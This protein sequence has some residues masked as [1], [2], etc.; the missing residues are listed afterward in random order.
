MRPHTHVLV[1]IPRQLHVLGA[2]PSHLHVLGAIPMKFGANVGE[3]CI[4]FR[5]Q[6]ELHLQ[7]YKTTQNET[8]L[9]PSLVPRLSY[10]RKKEKKGEL[11]VT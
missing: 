8:K 6:I 5:I 2:I 7:F 11:R 9:A 3:I 4:Q 10:K 1:T